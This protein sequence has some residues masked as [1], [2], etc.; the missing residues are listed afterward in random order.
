MARRTEMNKK[1]L[2]KCKTYAL[3]HNEV[4]CAVCG[5]TYA[6]SIAHKKKRR[7]YNS[8]EELSNPKEWLVLCYTHHHEIEF[9]KEKTEAL[10]SRL[11][12]ES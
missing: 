7:F 3:A 11:R 9:S 6:L 2:E 4:Q 8:V 1:A 5:T 12:P 10:F